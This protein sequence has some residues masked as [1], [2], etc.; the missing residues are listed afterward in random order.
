MTFPDFVNLSAALTGFPAST[1]K[2]AQDTQLV[3][4]DIYA[5]LSK[6]TNNIPAAQ[7][8]LLSTQWLEIADTPPADMEAKVKTEI[9]DNPAI[10]RLA[11]NIILM[12]YLGNWYDLLK[13]PNCFIFPPDVPANH[14]NQDH[15]ISSNVYKNSLVWGEMLAHPMGYSTG[16]YGYWELDPSKQQ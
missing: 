5:E 13:N 8:G 14:V 3:A 6:D 9:I 16:I 7:L 10:A 1:L 11:Q 15:V 2:P 12:W 4:E